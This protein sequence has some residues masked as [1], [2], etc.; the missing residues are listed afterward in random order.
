MRHRIV[1]TPEANIQGATKA[2]VVDAALASVDVPDV[3]GA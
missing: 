2:D 1:L 3:T